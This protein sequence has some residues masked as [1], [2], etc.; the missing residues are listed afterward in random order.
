MES[1]EIIPP[2]TP[3]AAPTSAW[4]TFLKRLLTSVIG[5]VIFFGAYWWSLDAFAWLIRGIFA[6]ILIFEWPRLIWPE[7]IIWWIPYSLLFIVGP[8]IA[9]TLPAYL[10]M[11]PTSTILYP[12]FIAWTYDSAAY[13]VGSLIGRHRIAP[14]LSPHKTWEG[15]FGGLLA[16]V[17]AHLLFVPFEEIQPVWLIVAVVFAYTGDISIS[18]FKRHAGLKDAGRI[19]PGH[20]GLLDRFNSVIFLSY[21]CLLRLFYLV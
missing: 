14:N 3:P 11:Q 12:F 9:L 6:F 17:G 2:N 16:V 19:L 1:N 4:S 15:F 8:A 13:I 10:E 5:A 18:R 20:G 21:W 7:R